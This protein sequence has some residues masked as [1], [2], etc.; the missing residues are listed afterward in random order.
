MPISEVPV[1]WLEPHLD[2]CKACVQ[3]PL[4]CLLEVCAYAKA[5]MI[6]KY[7]LRDLLPQA[8][9][10]LAENADLGAVLH[11]TPGGDADA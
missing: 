2:F 6:V 10:R 11:S 3:E 8:R 4:L 1:R 9:E 7:R 5:C